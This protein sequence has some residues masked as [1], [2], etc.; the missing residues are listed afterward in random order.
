MDGRLHYVVGRDVM[1]AGNRQ[2]G[3][4]HG[5]SVREEE[6]EHTKMTT[7]GGRHCDWFDELVKM[8][9]VVLL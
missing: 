6:R 7:G 1:V 9:L 5:N 8:V 2:A 3:R 4:L